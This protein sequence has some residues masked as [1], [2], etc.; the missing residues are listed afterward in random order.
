MA[1]PLSVAASIITLI[2]ATD[3]VLTCCYTYVGRVKNAEV[4]IDK[5]VQETSLL[6]GLF[7]NLHDLAQDEPENERLKDLIS[8]GGPLSI[9]KEALGEIER[10]LKSPSSKL[11]TSRR[12]LWPFDSKK[13]DE[14]LERIRKQKPTLL[15][16]LS[17]DNADISRE[18]KSGV[19]DIQIALESAQFQEK[20]EKILDWLRPND[21]KEKHLNSR[22]VHEHG[23][24]QWVLDHPDFLKWRTDPRQNI[25][26][27]IVGYFKIR[28]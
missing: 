16:S 11:T 23:S 10:K 5:V 28:C 9:C 1:D 26:V 20:R 27:R 25:W 14:I 19:K 18:I 22:R 7:L 13:L 17:I 3:Y 15:L 12:L 21:P 8:Q 6:K 24:N 2:Q 4:D